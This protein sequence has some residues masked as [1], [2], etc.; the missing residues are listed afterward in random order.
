M[1]KSFIASVSLSTATIHGYHV[2]NLTNEHYYSSIS[3]ELRLLRLV[4][5][6][7]WVDYRN[8]LRTSSG[9]REHCQSSEL[10]VP[11]CQLPC[12]KFGGCQFARST[13]KQTDVEAQTP[14]LL[15]PGRDQLTRWFGRG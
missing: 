1:V 6:Y 12:S 8:V 9:L 10:T 3:W 15:T 13:S 2:L 5:E 14:A 7:T 11:H 4:K